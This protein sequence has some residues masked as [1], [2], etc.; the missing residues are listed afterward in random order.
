MFPPDVIPLNLPGRRHAQW[1]LVVPMESRPMAVNAAFFREIKQDH[2]PLREVLNT[3]QLFSIAGVF[4]S[5]QGDLLVRHLG[6]LLDLLRFHF[7]LEE[8]YG[9][10]ESPRVADPEVARRA[11]ELRRQHIGLINELESLYGASQRVVGESA[12]HP[13]RTEVAD[14]L[15]G[16]LNRLQQHER[17]EN[18]LIDSVQNSQSGAS[19]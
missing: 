18:E 14:A 8:A 5:R 2:Q 10:F 17:Q 12:W 3:I 9:Y 13:A 4:V 11:A 6:Q 1:V 19:T 15:K 7:Y 16:F